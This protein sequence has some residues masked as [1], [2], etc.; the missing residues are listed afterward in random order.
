MRP[1]LLT[2]PLALVASCVF[3]QDHQTMKKTLSRH[4]EEVY[5]VP[6]ANWKL[7][8][9]QY[10]VID[11]DGHQVVKGAYTNGVKSGIWTYFNSA[12]AVIQRY[13]FSH[14]TLLYS[15]AD[16]GS[17]IHADARI[18][19]IV[20][21]SAN[22]HPAYKIGG[23]EYGFYLLYDERDIPAQVRSATS[24]AQMTYVL[25]ISEK[26]VLEGYTVIFTGKRIDDISIHKSVRG[27]PHDAYEFA[28]AT[29]DGKPVRSQ[30][31]WVV[32]LDIQ[33]YD[34]SV[35]NYSPTQRTSKN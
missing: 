34:H 28:A 17:I 13:D 16:P 1:L 3:A 12:G 26:G 30:I 27:L 15:A 33:H 7:K 4:L 10:Q 11:D 20:N 32:P 24:P 22:A 31:S 18:I 8:D 2:L 6:K 29:M 23:A 5:D 14:D 9:G 35:P 25:T 21:D 19:G